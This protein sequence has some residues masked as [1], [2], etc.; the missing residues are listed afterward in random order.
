MVQ[1]EQL[2]QSE[3]LERPHQLDQIQVLVDENR[4][5]L[6]NDGKNFYFGKDQN[7]SIEI[8][9]ELEIHLVNKNIDLLVGSSFYF[10]SNSS[11]GIVNKEKNIFLFSY[12][13]DDDTFSLVG[14]LFPKSV[15][16]PF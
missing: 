8:V 10:S 3:E 11:Y 16:N 14:Q 7:D 4:W 9:C 1:L 13:M 15:V 12:N 6:S 5:V 2:K